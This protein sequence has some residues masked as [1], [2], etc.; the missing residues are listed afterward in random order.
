MLE[1]SC[2][3]LLTTAREDKYVPGLSCELG[4]QECN[5]NSL[6]SGMSGRACENQSSSSLIA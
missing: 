2:K 6:S 3:P 1:P 5:S 4:L